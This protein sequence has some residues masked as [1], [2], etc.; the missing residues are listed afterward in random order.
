MAFSLSEATDTNCGI[1]LH[2]LFLNPMY[3]LCRYIS[4]DETP[5]DRSKWGVLPARLQRCVVLWPDGND[6]SNQLERERKNGQFSSVRPC[7]IYRQ[8]HV[9]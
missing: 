1:V 7:L 4:C 3:Y 2:R 6:S 9:S 5:T 8:S